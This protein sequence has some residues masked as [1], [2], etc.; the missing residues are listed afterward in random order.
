MLEK[1][2]AKGVKLLDVFIRVLLYADDGALVAASAVDLQCMLDILK[3][4]CS[5]W[6]MV[7]NVDKTV[8]I[9]FN[10]PSDTPRESYI[11]HYDGRVLSVV[12]QFKYLGLVFHE[13]GSW[14]QMILNRLHAAKSLIAIW[15]RRFCTWVF[16]SCIVQRLFT[17]CVMPAL[18][19][20]VPL[21]G[22]GPYSSA[23]WKAVEAFWR[24]SARTMVGVP[25]RTPTAAVFGDLGWYEYS[26]RAAYQSVKFLMRVIELSDSTLTRKALVVQQQMCNRAE[27]MRISTWMVR[28]KGTLLLGPTYAVN[29]WSAL[30]AS[31]GMHIDVKR[32][33]LDE[34]GIES[35]VRLED[36]FFSALKEYERG[37]WMRE[38][39]G[40]GKEQGDYCVSERFECE[41]P[42]DANVRALHVDQA[43]HKMR[44]YAL[45]KPTFKL[46][47]ETYLQCV[48]STY[49]R[50]L[51]ARFRMGVL[52]LRI[53]TGRYELCGFGGTKK[54]LPVE[55]RVCR[56]CD[57]CKVEDEIHFL[58]ECP[59]FEQP[60]REL[61]KISLHSIPGFGSLKEGGDVEGM[62]CAILS[63]DIAAVC[64]G[65]AQFIRR[66]F[67]LRFRILKRLLCTSKVL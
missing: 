26:V 43:G 60:R 42:V 44:T 51:L 52:P 64:C 30:E 36:E 12:E 13:S 47:F 37:M 10:H 61:I 56:C 4:Y 33:I 59:T 45:C 16:N 62:F 31:P 65:T 5:Q 29:L 9:V 28:L 18:D 54:G 6:K 49:E 38:I 41:N 34:S 55:F 20:G 11:F 22:V 32:V 27:Q 46:K 21:W 7:V 23:D 40:V 1:Y 17:T 2:G 35:E 24:A 19:Y 25:K 48:E 66:A 15:R 53:E 63:S 67:L 58:L 8:V 39:Q 14:T 50:Q 3:V 57:L